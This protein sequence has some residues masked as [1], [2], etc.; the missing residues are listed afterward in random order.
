ML[1]HWSSPTPSNN[2]FMTFAI[3]HPYVFIFQANLSGPALKFVQS[4][5]RSSR[6]GSQLRLIPLFVLPKI[7]WSPKN[8][9]LPSAI[10]NDRFLSTLWSLFREIWEQSFRMSVWGYD[11]TSFNLIEYISFYWLITVITQPY[12]YVW[13][14]SHFLGIGLKTGRFELQFS[15]FIIHLKDW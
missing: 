9:R 7:K 3:P 15:V 5:K 1:L 12:E 10:N 2:F 6:L 13:R 14:V 11:G 4:F 8:P